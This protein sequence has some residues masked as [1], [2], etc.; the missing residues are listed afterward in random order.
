MK[1]WCE[2]RQN[3]WE[4]DGNRQPRNRP[5]HISTY[6]LWPTWHCRSMRKGIN[7]I[8]AAGTLGYTY[9]TGE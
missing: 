7:S 6:E 1:Y 2:D 9:G 8:I 4:I 5:T 3:E